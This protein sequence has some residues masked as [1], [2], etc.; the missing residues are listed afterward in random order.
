MNRMRFSFGERLVANFKQEGVEA[1]FSQGDLSM[2]DIQL[3]AEK[4]GLKVVG[5]RHEASAI[6]ITPLLNAL[7]SCIYR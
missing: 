1:V 5:P 4:Q 6:F 2:K 7:N 3:H